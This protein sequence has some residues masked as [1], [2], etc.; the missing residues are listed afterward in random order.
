MKIITIQQT[1]TGKGYV[2]NVNGFEGATA[3]AKDEITALQYLVEKLESKNT[4]FIQKSDWTWS[5]TNQ[6]VSSK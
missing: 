4:G 6:D 5:K 3:I 1:K 2:A